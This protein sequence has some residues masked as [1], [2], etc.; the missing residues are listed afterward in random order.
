M[1]FAD[2]SPELQSRDPDDPEPSGLLNVTRS[3]AKPW[4]SLIP[5]RF[6][7][8]VLAG[9][10]IFHTSLVGIALFFDRLNE[11]PGI[12]AVEI[13]VELVNEEEAQ[14]G[15]KSGSGQ[16]GSDSAA[17]LG[18]K[19]PPQGEAGHPG[20]GGTQD[21]ARQA[22]KPEEQPAKPPEPQAEKPLRPEQPKSAENKPAGPKPADQ[23]PVENANKPA[24]SKAAQNPAS[25]EKPVL[26]AQKEL[27]QKETAQKPQPPDPPKPAE[28]PKQTGQKLQAFP[29]PQ[30]EQP[31]QAAQQEPQNPMAP[32]RPAP[33]PA[34]LSQPQD[35]L[36]LAIPAP[37]PTNDADAEPVSYKV[38]VFGQLERA[39]EYPETARQRHATGHV[40]V[41]FSVDDSGQPQEI[42]MIRSSGQDD[43]DTEALSMITRSAPFPVPPPGAQRQ[44][45]VDIG[46]GGP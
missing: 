42:S 22:P 16:P 6:F 30:P 14:G 39:K 38:V 40:I 11:I 45:A 19:T 7:V 25:Q 15:Q 23:K 29:A 46:F 26:P 41:S 32:Q 18:Q 21:T 9:S 34:F 35:G 33:M 2:L 12:G 5:S 8:I 37:L 28:T 4:R 10:L 44:F 36:S 1:A 20:T 13:P 27:A 3:T 24:E 17:P 31:P 43:L